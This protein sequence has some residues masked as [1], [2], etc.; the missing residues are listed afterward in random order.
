[1]VGERPVE[2]LMALALIVLGG[3]VYWATQL[4][5]KSQ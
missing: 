4:T 2:G 5:K 3:L 1:L